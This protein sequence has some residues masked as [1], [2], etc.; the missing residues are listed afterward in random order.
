MTTEQEIR[1]KIKIFR[2]TSQEVNLYSQ[3]LNDKSIR[4]FKFK[5]DQDNRFKIWFFTSSLTLEIPLTTSLLFSI[6]IPDKV[7]FADKKLKEINGIGKIYTDNSKNEQIINC[8]ELLKDELKS[9]DLD[10]TEGL[11]VYRN[12]LHL[13]LKHNRQLLSEIEVCK[14]IK[15]IIEVNFPDKINGTDYSDLPTDLRQILLKF[16]NLINSNDFERDEIIERL[17]TIQRKDLIKVIE[18][19]LKAI[20]LFLDTFDNKPLTEGAIGLQCLAELT[21]QLTNDEK[22]NHS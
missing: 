22:K 17:T 1:N 2:P 10:N 6:N 19:K 4:L 16:E 20:D 13:V 14:K 11:T 21:I 5:D 3:N 18:S 15:T 7:C 12:S 9:L 8:V